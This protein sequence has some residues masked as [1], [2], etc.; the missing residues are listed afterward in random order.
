M[1]FF[2]VP[3]IFVEI[4]ETLLM[5]DAARAVYIDARHR[6]PRARVQNTLDAKIGSHF[7]NG[8]QNRS[9]L[10]DVMRPNKRGSNV[11]T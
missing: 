8:L 4:A 10:I 9:D 7:R 6:S 3:I 11:Y 2:V 1:P 5:I